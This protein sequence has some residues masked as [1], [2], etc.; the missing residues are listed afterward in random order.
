M[1]SVP[2]RPHLSW[3]EETETPPTKR[4]LFQSPPISTDSQDC[5]FLS[6]VILGVPHGSFTVSLKWIVSVYIMLIETVMSQSHQETLPW[7]AA[8]KQEVDMVEDIPSLASLHHCA[9]SASL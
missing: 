8:L 9:P 5:L 2:P 6:T 1:P 4:P 3:G 7:D